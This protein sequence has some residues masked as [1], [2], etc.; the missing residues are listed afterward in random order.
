M[1][2]FISITAIV[3][4]IL[5]IIVPRYILPACEYEG[6]PRMHCS[7][8]AYAEFILGGVLIALGSIL[9]FVKIDALTLPA[10]VA[11]L[12]LYFIAYLLPDTFGY[13]KSTRMPC[14]YGMV[15]G[16]RVL[17]V[18]GAIL[19]VV[20]IVRSIKTYRKKGNT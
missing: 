14:N 12:C 20:A 13:C 18:S 7:D 11:A 19:M 17:A 9:A 8:T 15:P 2:R 16:I 5:I 1:K 10:A 6:F 4:G 3:T